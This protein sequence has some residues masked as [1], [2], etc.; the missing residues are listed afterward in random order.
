MK[1]LEGCYC[2]KTCTLNGEIYRDEDVWIDGCKNCTCLVWGYFYVMYVA[3]MNKY[4]L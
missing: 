3:S 4:I 2:E 1:T